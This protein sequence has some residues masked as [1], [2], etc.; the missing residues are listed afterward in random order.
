VWSSL[1]TATPSPP[2]TNAPSTK[3]NPPT[4]RPRGPFRGRRYHGLHA[5]PAVGAVVPTTTGFLVAQWMWW[6]EAARQSGA[7]MRDA[8]MRAMPR[9]VGDQREQVGPSVRTPESNHYRFT[10]A[11]IIDRWS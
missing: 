6:K 3:S 1:E 9:D 11:F 8:A 2:S 4:T 7:E 5:A 10:C